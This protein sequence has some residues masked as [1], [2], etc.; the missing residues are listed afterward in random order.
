MIVYNSV[1][2][3]P[4]RLLENSSDEQPETRGP[5]AVFGFPEKAPDLT[6]SASISSAKQ[7]P[8]EK[9]YLEPPEEC[10]RKCLSRC[11]GVG[12]GQG[13][14][15]RRRKKDKEASG[16][17]LPCSLSPAQYSLAQCDTAGKAL[18]VGELLVPWEYQFVRNDTYV[19]V[20]YKDKQNNV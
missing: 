10:F 15:K 5:Y 18:P 19:E 4:E 20:C 13:P 11:V 2:E 16:I 17:S 3:S 14:T 8:E 12:A 1:D 6:S 9:S 7:R